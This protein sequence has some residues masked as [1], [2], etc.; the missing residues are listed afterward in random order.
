MNRT[1]LRLLC[2]LLAGLLAGPLVAAP[3]PSGADYCAEC[4]VP[5]RTLCSEEEGETTEEPGEQDPEDELVLGFDEED[6]SVT[7]G[8]YQEMEL[9]VSGNDGEELSWKITEQFLPPGLE[10][11][12]SSSD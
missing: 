12:D 2:M 3:I 1:M 8:K 5:D 10:L 4:D 9:T 6:L 7:Y 11:E